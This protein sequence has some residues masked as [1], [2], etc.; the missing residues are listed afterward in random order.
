MPAGVPA[1][2][3]EAAPQGREADGGLGWGHGQSAQQWPGS[4]LKALG[5]QGGAGVTH[6]PS[7]PLA[8]ASALVK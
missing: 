3:K 7:A 8:P 1:R 4:C 5:S 6:R 2:R